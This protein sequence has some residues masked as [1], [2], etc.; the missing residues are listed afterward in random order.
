[1]PTRWKRPSVRLS[2][3]SGRSPCSTCTSTLVWLSAA[4]ENIS[5]LRVGNRRVARDQR[6]HHAAQ[7][8]DAE[9]Q[10]RDVEQQQILDVAGEHA[11]LNRRADGDDFVGVDA[12]VRL[13]P[14]QILDDRL[15]ARDARRAADQHDLVDLR[16]VDAGVAQRLLGR[17][18]GLLQ[19]LLDQRLE[20]G[21]RQLHRQVLRP[22][23]VGGDERQ[24]DLASPSPT[25]APSWPSPPPRADAAAPCGPCQIDAVALL[26][27]AR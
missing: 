21:A 6:R 3:A 13:L 19:Q 2:R 26:E 4:V 14:E 18:D 9:R 11:G 22:A 24:V 8:L 20:L 17:P 16:R 27:L 7:R 25:T 5:L 12:L 1:M 15:H 23:G 10:R